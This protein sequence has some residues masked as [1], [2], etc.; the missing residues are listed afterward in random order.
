MSYRFVCLFLQN[1]KRQL[2]TDLVVEQRIRN[3]GS[4]R[5]SPAS[6]DDEQDEDDTRI[7]NEDGS[8]D[9]FFDCNTD[10][11]RL[12][13]TPVLNSPKAVQPREAPSANGGWTSYSQGD[14][15]LSCARQVLDRL[16]RVWSD[17]SPTTH[18]EAMSKTLC[19][20]SPLS[21]HCPATTLPCSLSLLI[22]CPTVESM[23]SVQENPFELSLPFYYLALPCAAFLF[24]SIIGY[25]MTQD[26]YAVD[27]T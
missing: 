20:V 9:V 25:S 12:S 22:G 7:S 21:C 10:L 24:T 17:S 16:V 6:T 4:E 5:E 14:L 2:E 19:S 8:E 15:P 27:A 1:A 23:L 13:S 11:A 3:R 18:L 26:T